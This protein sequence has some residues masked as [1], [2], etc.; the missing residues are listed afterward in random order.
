VVG[1][2]LET[3]LMTADVWLLIHSHHNSM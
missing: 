1:V 3:L 2:E